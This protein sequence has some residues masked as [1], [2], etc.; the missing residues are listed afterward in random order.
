MQ[1]F[2]AIKLSVKTIKFKHLYRFSGL[3]AAGVIESKLP[4]YCL[5]GDTVNYAS[6][7][8]YTGFSNNI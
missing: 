1:D 2:N 5:F 6:L 8:K 7:M 3:V 4:K